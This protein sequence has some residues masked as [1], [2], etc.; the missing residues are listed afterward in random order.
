MKLLH[1]K[2]K[3]HVLDDDKRPVTV[4]KDGEH[5]W[6]IVYDESPEALNGTKKTMTMSELLNH[7]KK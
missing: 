1:K 7:N 6:R 3:E 2:D 5:S 4:I